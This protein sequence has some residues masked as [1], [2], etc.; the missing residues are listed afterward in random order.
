MNARQYDGHA[1]GHCQ[2]CDNS[3]TQG[4]CDAMGLYSCMNR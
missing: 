2:E 4:I 3:A 1:N